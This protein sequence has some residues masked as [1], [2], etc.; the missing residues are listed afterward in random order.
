MALVN[1]PALPIAAPL[2]LGWLL[3]PDVAYRI[4]RPE[5]HD[6]APLPEEQRRR[7][8]C[9]VRRTWL[10]FEH[11]VGPEDHWLPPDHFQEDLT[12]DSG[13]L[14]NK[15]GTFIPSPI[16]FSGLYI[17]RVIPVAVGDTA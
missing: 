16:R 4:S 6:S 5:K 15:P 2:L 14:A 11:F 7:L 8:R 1:P 3:A 9:L 17:R 13:A 10:Y 12:Q